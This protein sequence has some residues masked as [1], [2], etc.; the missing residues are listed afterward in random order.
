MGMF[1]GLGA[2]AKQASDGMNQAAKGAAAALEGAGKAAVDGLGEAGRAVGK[3][4]G[5]AIGAVKGAAENF[6]TAMVVRQTMRLPMVQVDRGGFLRK[7]LRK[8]YKD[9]VI[10]AAIKGNPAKAGIGRDRIDAIARQVIDY[11]TNKVSMI[12]FA[13]G[14]PGGTAMAVAVP[15]DVTQ[16]FGAML[17]VI[18]KL[19]YLYGFDDFE[20]NEDEIDDA[21][22]NEIMVFLGVMFG[23][24]G[25]VAAVNAI[26]KMA[27]QH[28]VK[29]VARKALAKGVVFPVA[30][31]VAQAVG[32]RMTKEIFAK[33]VSKAVP[34]VGG[35]ISGGMTYASFKPCA[36]SLQ[37]SF[38]GLNLSNPKFY[39]K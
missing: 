31:K 17:I 23:V 36:L 8:Y 21:T 7:E 20:L 19:A 3:A 18:Q 25:A 24:H 16:Y 27:E 5:D 9:D 33:G 39:R 4:G 30:K 12:S 2:L 29:A 34:V 22:M 26:A 35:V 6:D 15:L 11:E 38:Q 1:D 13:A 37:K 32:V 14:M 10:D 28:V